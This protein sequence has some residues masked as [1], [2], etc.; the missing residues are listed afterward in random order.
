MAVV[1]RELTVRNGEVR[2]ENVPGDEVL[3]RFRNVGDSETAR[4][5]TPGKNGACQRAWGVAAIWATL[6]QEYLGR[7]V[8]VATLLHRPRIFAR[9]TA[10][11]G[12]N[13]YPGDPRKPTATTA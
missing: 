4:Q 1:Q 10:N 13:R 5:T 2:L 7:A 11:Y 8:P 3:I 6:C 9:D 12:R